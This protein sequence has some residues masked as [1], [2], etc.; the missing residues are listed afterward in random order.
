[1]SLD[2]LV[3][4]RFAVLRKFGRFDV[5][6]ANLDRLAAAFRRTPGAPA[7]RYITMA[8]KSNLD[9]IPEIVRVSRERWLSTDNTIR[10]TD[11]ILAQAIAKR[12]CEHI[13]RDGRLLAQAARLSA[14]ARP[15][16]DLP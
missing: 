10:Y 8:F 12:M 1:M 16:G 6:A 4:E 11:H 15:A 9:E 13:A 3:P 7:L 14:R 2:T 5:F